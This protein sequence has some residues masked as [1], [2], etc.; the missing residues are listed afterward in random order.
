MSSGAVD[1]AALTR[2]MR[3]VLGSDDRMTAFRAVSASYLRC[4]A[5]NRAELDFAAHTYWCEVHSF[6]GADAA[7]I[8]EGLA[9]L[10]PDVAKR[11]AMQRCLAGVL[12]A[13]GSSQPPPRQAASG[14]PHQRV[15]ADGTTVTLVAPPTP[16]APP[17][18]IP[19]IDIPRAFS[20]IPV[21]DYSGQQK[22][23]LCPS[24]QPATADPV[25]GRQCTFGDRCRFAHS[26]EE[27]RP[28]H[29]MALQKFD[30]G[31]LIS[32]PPYDGAPLLIKDL[33][34]TSLL[35]AGSDAG[36]LPGT[37]RE[38][39]ACRSFVVHGKCHY[40]AN[41]RFM[42]PCPLA[43]ARAAKG[44]LCLR[45]DT[46]RYRC[47]YAHSPSELTPPETFLRPARPLQPGRAQTGSVGPT[48]RLRIAGDEA[49]VPWGVVLATAGARGAGR[50]SE[51]C[52]DS[53]CDRWHR[54]PR[55][56][57]S[58]VYLQ[59]RPAFPNPHPYANRAEVLEAARAELPFADQLCAA[60]HSGPALDLAPGGRGAGRGLDVGGGRG[61]WRGWGVPPAPPSPESTSR[62]VEMA[63]RNAGFSVKTKK[64]RAGR[65]DPQ[66]G[67]EP[68]F[69]TEDEPEP[70]DHTADCM[71]PA[72]AYSNAPV[73][74]GELDTFGALGEL[75]ALAADGDDGGFS[76]Q[77]GSQ[78][79]D[80]DELLGPPS[81]HADA[82]CGET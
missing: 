18:A 57:L 49:S 34:P 75:M 23:L 78:V 37:D 17:P 7:E 73:C 48:L 55:I 10:L 56:H 14:L 63:F 41:C 42:H 43:V 31:M 4:G 69:G 25:P 11:A 30:A 76:G 81:G 61:T 58:P 32:I 22:A 19:G 46:C 64:G 21:K 35:K 5:A 82:S 50:G 6:F 53:G 60:P 27:L 12:A 3:A 24:L 45:L 70:V 72:L 13:A 1:G 29:G 59:A 15:L 47:P 54:C 71:D 44:H 65:V 28:P 74:G 20:A 26:F 68:R 39:W 80:F 67:G 33:Y 77:L 2:R 51:L 40:W 62:G 52:V 38:L 66:P 9:S 16:A 36:V 8:W 79:I